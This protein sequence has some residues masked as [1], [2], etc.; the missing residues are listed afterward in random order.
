MVDNGA[1]G[2]DVARRSVLRCLAQADEPLGALEVS[3]RTHLST[4]V[5]IPILT[6]L[7]EEALVRRDS[8]ATGSGRHD[9]TWAYTLTGR[10][11]RAVADAARRTG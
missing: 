9:T 2:D 10:G 1:A 3:R 5:A 7:A 11:N 8:V 4:L 6:A